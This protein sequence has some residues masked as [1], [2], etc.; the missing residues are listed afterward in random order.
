MEKVITAA[1][2]RMSNLA[3]LLREQ[4]VENVNDSALLRE[5]KLLVHTNPEFSLLDVRAKAIRW[6]CDGRPNSGGHKHS[7]PS[8]CAA[9]YNQVQ[10]QVDHL[11]NNSSTSQIAE[12]AAMLQKQ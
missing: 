10:S 7:V 2:G 8:L 12:L 1:S 11:P 3:I 6:E 4:F 9:Q 5:L